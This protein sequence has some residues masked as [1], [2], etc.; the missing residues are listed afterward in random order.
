MKKLLLAMLIAFSFTAYSQQVIEAKTKKQN[1]TI[2]VST[3]SLDAS[4]QRGILKNIKNCGWFT[5]TNSPTANYDVTFS[6]AGGGKVSVV[7]KDT[8]GNVLPKGQYSHNIST[9]K[10]NWVQH[11]LV[12]EILSRVYNPKAKICSSRIAFSGSRRGIKEIYTIDYDGGNLKQETNYRSI[13]VEPAWSPDN[14]YL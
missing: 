13:T 9:L 2:K 1:P 11:R 6:N 14:R 3:V 7:I 4:I 8:S 10:G 5:L 12:D